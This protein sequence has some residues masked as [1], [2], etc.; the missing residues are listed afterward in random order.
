MSGRMLR[1][2]EVAQR[3]SCSVSSVWSFSSKK[4]K[5]PDFPRRYKIG[6]GITGFSEEE[7]EAYIESRKK[8]VAA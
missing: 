6:P 8:V 2:Q 5:I 4:S 3:L 7:I 1:V